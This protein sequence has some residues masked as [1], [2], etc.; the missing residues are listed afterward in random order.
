MNEIGKT[1]ETTLELE[2][3]LSIP[4]PELKS[5]IPTDECVN[6]INIEYEGSLVDSKKRFITGSID[7][8]IHLYS[9]D[10]IKLEEF[11]NHNLII[12]CLEICK[13]DSQFSILASCSLDYKFNYSILNNNKINVIHQ[14]TTPYIINSFDFHKINI[15]K[16]ITATDEGSINLFDLT[17]LTSEYL[18]MFTSLQ[19]KNKKKKSEINTSIDPLVTMKLNTNSILHVMW[20]DESNFITACDDHSIQQINIELQKSNTKI[21]TS[22]SSINDLDIRQDL[23]LT[24]HDDGSIRIYD[25]RS[26]VISSK[27]LG[28]SVWASSAC[29]NPLNSYLIGSTSYDKSFKLWDLRGNREL[30]TINLNSKGYCGKWNGPQTF[31]IACDENK[32]KSIEI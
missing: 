15:Y 26:G 6:K 8:S 23:V 7:G 28:H 10:N 31:L 13:I 3:T 4:Q 2:Y 32:I 21:M 5:E 18:K 17:K 25:T 19:S 29:F 22:Y 20:K 12:N 9:E 27:F 30:F 11:K 1:S 14:M 24:S 16:F